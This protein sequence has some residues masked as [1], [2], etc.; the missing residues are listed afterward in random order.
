VLYHYGAKDPLIP[1]EI[2]AQISAA[3]PGHAVHVYAAGHG[4][5]C[6]ERPDYDAPSAALALERTLA[7]FGDHLA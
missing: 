3:R 2:V 7:F 1:P 6:G 4:F 5:N